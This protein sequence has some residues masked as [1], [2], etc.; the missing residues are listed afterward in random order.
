MLDIKFSLSGSVADPD[1]LHQAR[2]VVAT[3]H[4]LFGDA[5][6]PGGV[7]KMRV[8]GVEVGGSFTPVALEQIGGC[9]LADPNTPADADE[10]ASDGY[11]VEDETDAATAF[12]GA[13]PALVPTGDLDAAGIPWDERIHASTKTRN[14]DDTWT[15]RRNTPD[16]TFD[17]VMTELKGGAAVPPPPAAAATAPPPPPPSAPVPTTPAAPAPSPVPAAP[18]ASSTAPA[19]PAADYEKP[20]TDFPQLMVKVTKAQ[21]AGKITVPVVE[22]FI[23]LMGVEGKM[24]ELMKHP[25]ILPSVDAMIIDHIRNAS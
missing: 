21:A 3:M 14:K 19:A 24:M 6:F 9:I 2:A 20:A 25:D 4:H 8:G 7:V 15:R 11:P 18:A 17:A 5:V 23:A 22:G 10:P 13:P 16:A 12:G 1:I